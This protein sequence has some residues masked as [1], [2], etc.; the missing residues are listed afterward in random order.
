MIPGSGKIPWRRK[1]QPTAVLLPR[2]SH[3]ERSQVS[4]T[5]RVAKSRTQLSMHTHPIFSIPEL[6]YYFS[7]LL[8]SNSLKPYTSCSVIN[9]DLCLGFFGIVITHKN[10]NC[11]TKIY[12]NLFF[13]P[14]F[15]QSLQFI[16]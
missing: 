8:L 9:Y 3:G 13:I 6:I 11:N 15:L 7:T 12:F 10:I 14:M 4:Y 2:K 1:W 5:P 16:S